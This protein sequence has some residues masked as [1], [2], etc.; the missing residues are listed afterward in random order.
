MV[1]RVIKA[2]ANEVHRTTALWRRGHLVILGQGIRTALALVLVLA[3]LG[4]AYG[5]DFTGTWEVTQ[6]LKERDGF[7]W[8]REVKY[9]KRMTLE[10]RGGRLV[11]W[12]TDQTGSSCAFAV[13]Q[14]LNRDR[15]LLLVNCGETKSPAA[16]APIHHAKL[17]NGKCHGIVIAEERLFE[18]VAVRRK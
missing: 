18:W 2:E 11:G 3:T 9:P 13:T 1:D 7:P 17:R 8:S 10:M 12:Y 4:G 14:L 5:D 16:Y 15:D 6:I